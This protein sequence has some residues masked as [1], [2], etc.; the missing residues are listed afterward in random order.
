MGNKFFCHTTVNI[1]HIMKK[2]CTSGDHTNRTYAFKLFFFLTDPESGKSM[3]GINVTR[4]RVL[5]TNKHCLSSPSCLYKLT[6]T[7][8]RSV[9]HYALIKLMRKYK[10]MKC[11]LDP[12]PR[13]LC[14]WR[15]HR[16][17]VSSTYLSSGAC[18][19]LLH[20]L[21]PPSSPSFSGGHASQTQGR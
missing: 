6:V 21:P 9:P 16:W 12:S 11:N 13:L 18:R 3:H 5:P 7:S 8:T 14:K 2:G 10:K 20:P 15:F 4:S 1:S 19:A 17:Y